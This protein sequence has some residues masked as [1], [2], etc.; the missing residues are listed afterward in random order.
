MM[1]ETDNNVWGETRSPIHTGTSAGGSSG[2]EAALLAMRGS[3]LG[4]GTDIAGSI[5]I[6][7][8]WTHLYG[9]RPS[10]GRFPVLNI[11]TGISGQE[12]VQ[13]TN[14]PIAR[15]LETLQLYCSTVLSERTKVWRLDPKCLP[16]SWRENVLQPPSR[17]LRLGIVGNHDFSVTCH[18]PVERALKETKKALID[19]GHEILEWYVH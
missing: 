2:G 18:P 13:A 10:A 14:G 5:R 7:A 4:I 1:M 19:A 12:F 3:P 9:L 17:K 16:I 6:P 15:H 8:A 11:R